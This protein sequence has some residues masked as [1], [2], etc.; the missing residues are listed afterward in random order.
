MADKLTDAELIN[1]VR[2][3]EELGPTEAAKRLGLRARML[4]ERCREAVS[5]GLSAKTKISDQTAAMKLR[6]REAEAELSSI[7][8]DNLDTASVREEIFSLST[9]PFNPPDWLTKPTKPGL[10]G[11][12][13]TI[14][15]DFHWGER[16]FKDQ[17]NG[18]NEFNR[19]I[20]RERFKRLVDSV[21][22]LTLHHMVNPNYPGIV[23]CLGG[24]MM[25]GTIH[26]EL[27]VTNDGDVNQTLMEL[28]EYLAAGLRHLADKFGRVFVPCVVGNHARMTPKPRAKNH[29]HESFEYL[30][31]LRLEKEFAGDKRVQFLIP[32]SSDAHFIVLGHR[33]LLTHGDTLGVKGGDGIIGALGPIA[34]GATKVGRAESQVDRAFDTLLIGHWHTYIPRGGATPVLVN[35]AL[36]GYDEYARLF[37]RVPYSRP[38]QALFFVHPKYGITAQWEI[39]LDENKAKSDR[40][41]DWVTWDASNHR[42]G[43]K[44]LQPIQFGRKVA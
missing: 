25:T 17:M 43:E 7:K 14:W 40:R 11:V 42:G 10:P 33:F 32:T 26:E 21:I 35:G 28:Q 23:V 37:L 18:L 27:A 15:S 16:V 4:H 12:P 36:K 9:L 41:S 3:R 24:D 20:A 29:T 22:D 13:V 1:T 31:Y 30:L 2:L 8:K 19:K 39:Y 44:P 5:R 34:R 6:L 38:S